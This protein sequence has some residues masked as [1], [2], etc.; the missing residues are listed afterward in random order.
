MQY[1]FYDTCSLLFYGKEIFNESN[2]QIYI[3]NITLKELESIKTSYSKDSEIKFRAR[4]IIN[5]LSDYEDKYHIINYKNSWNQELLTYDILSDNYDSKIILTA[6]KLKQSINQDILFITQDL[7]CKKIAQ[8]LGLKVEYLKEQNDQYKGYQIINFKNDEE[9]ASLYEK[10]YST[11]NLFD[12]N[13][14]QYLLLR[15]KPANQII[16]KYKIVNNKLER[17]PDFI[18]FESKMFGKVKPKDEYQFIAMDSLLNNKIT[19]LRGAAGTGKSYLALS[20]LFYLLERNK[21]EKIIIFCNTVATLGSAKLGYYPGSKDEK[22]L[23]SQI[24]NFLISKLGDKEA[25][26]ELIEK[27]ILILLPMSD[28][29]GFDSTGMQAGIYI[30]EAQNMD[31]ELM[32]LALQRVGEDSICI[33]DGDS[34]AQVD[35]SM[36]AGSNNGMRRVSEIFRNEKIYGEV[37]L[38][39][40]YRS[41]IARIAQRM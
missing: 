13:E 30:T 21:I 8:N 1:L 29:R 12:L 14:N 26:I 22:L 15:D 20:Y 37:T 23:D 25:V 34:D 41:Q 9:L 4:K 17:L 28:I 35:L 6:L 10:I 40:I 32:R 24:G 27:G 11:Q 36:Y 19:M 39:N 31:I 7:C 18:A 5:L 38:P 2:N 3:S 33:L 16:D